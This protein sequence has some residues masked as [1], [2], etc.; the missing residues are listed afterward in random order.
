M[1]REPTGTGL[2]GQTGNKPGSSIR[3]LFDAQDEGDRFSPEAECKGPSPLSL[4]C[5]IFGLAILALMAL[6]VLG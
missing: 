1:D 4:L 3:G 5:L 6:G 2:I